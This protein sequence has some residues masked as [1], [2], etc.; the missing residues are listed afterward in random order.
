MDNATARS[1]R[2]GEMAGTCWARLFVVHDRRERVCGGGARTRSGYSRVRVLATTLYATGMAVLKSV[3]ALSAENVRFGGKVLGG[4][5]MGWDAFS[6]SLSTE[7]KLGK[8]GAAAER[9]EAFPGPHLAA[10][11]LLIN[12]K[13]SPIAYTYRRST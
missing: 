6:R 3:R 4:G 11:Q 8:G 2:D 12:L 7:P 1:S 9:L 10:R 13:D 5:G